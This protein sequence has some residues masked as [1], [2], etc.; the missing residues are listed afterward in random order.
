M[1]KYFE[2]IDKIS[3]TFYSSS[4]QNGEF[5]YPKGLK[6]ISRDISDYRNRN[7]NR[8]YNYLDICPEKDRLAILV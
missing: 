5:N 7:S 4:P 2:I 6:S 3:K 8:D 1:I